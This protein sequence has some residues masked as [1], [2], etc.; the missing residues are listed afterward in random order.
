MSLLYHFKSTIDGKL[1]G[2]SETLVVQNG[3]RSSVREYITISGS[4]RTLIWSYKNRSLEKLFFSYVNPKERNQSYELWVFQSKGTWIL[5]KRKLGSVWDETVGASS[6]M[7]FFSSASVSS[8]FGFQDIR[9]GDVF[10]HLEQSVEYRSVGRAPSENSTSLSMVRSDT[11]AK[12]DTLTFSTAF[13]NKVQAPSRVEFPYGFYGVLAGEKR[14]TSLGAKMSPMPKKVTYTASAKKYRE[15]AM[16]FKSFDE[17]RLSGILQSKNLKKSR[18]IF[19][20]LH[21]SGPEDRDAGSGY[22]G[23]DYFRGSIRMFQAL[24]GALSEKGHASYRY[25]KRGVGE[26][27]G[28]WTQTSRTV[29]A[30]DALYVAKGLKARYPSHKVVLLGVSEGANL[31]VSAARMSEGVAVDAIVLGGAPA[32]TIDRVML[33]KIKFKVKQTVHGKSI[34]LESYKKWTHIFKHLKVLEKKY[35]SV[36]S[37]TIFQGYPISWWFDHVRHAPMREGKVLSLPVLMLHGSLDSE[38]L[39][40]QGKKLFA[41]LRKNNEKNKFITMKG[42]NHFFSPARRPLG[43]EYDVPQEINAKFA[44]NIDKWVRYV[45]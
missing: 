22:E 2:Y 36:S 19:V 17:C 35:A 40:N 24:A 20:L 44:N 28:D 39:L 30:K 6:N 25:D 21:G 14:S 26:S 32:E 34:L 31:A 12:K 29:L 43:V 45:F 13:E 42:L 9:K 23:R 38:V 8:F 16:G 11:F 27:G 41:C 3:E 18:V 10:F 7:R 15:V 5:R 1:L 33:G 37:Q 4:R